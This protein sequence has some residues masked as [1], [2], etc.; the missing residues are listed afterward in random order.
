MM[1]LEATEENRSAASIVSLVASRGFGPVSPSRHAIAGGLLVS[2]DRQELR[3]I[4]DLYGRKVADG[5]WRDYAIAASGQKAVFSIYRRA[6]ELPLY[7]I[8][9]IPRARKQGAYCVVAASGLIL[10]RDND[11]KHAIKV[12]D[13]KLKVISG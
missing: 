3:D 11:L 7:R 4:L 13:K 9:K 1:D 5:E 6:A 10:R 2:F 12:L 8:E